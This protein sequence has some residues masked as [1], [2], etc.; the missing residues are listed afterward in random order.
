[1]NDV[2][3]DPLASK[4]DRLLSKH[5]AT[6]D[7]RNIPVLTDLVE[8]PAWQPAPIAPEVL[9][10]SPDVL[11]ALDDDEIELLSQDIFMRVSQRIDSEL[12]IKL[13]AQLRAQLESQ[14][15]ATINHVLA[16]MKQSIA[17]D[18]GDAVNAALADRLRLK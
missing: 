11:A 12:A 4:V 5:S 8:A 10:E 9:A 14:L 6:P 13:E 3:S 16:D 18:I 17:N 2:P 15:H 1:M 7:D